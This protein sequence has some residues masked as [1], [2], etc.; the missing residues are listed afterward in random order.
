MNK[1][2]PKYRN[3]II[4]N[5]FV[6]SILLF[7]STIN[8]FA[9]ESDSEI[10]KRAMRDEMK[11]SMDS[12]NYKDFSKPFFIGY[13]YNQN[14]SL[15]ISAKLGAITGS[16]ISKS[17]DNSVRLMVGD[18][19]MN[20]ENYYSYSSFDNGFN[21]SYLPTPLE[22]EYYGIRR[23]F[24]ASSDAV[25]KS[26]GELYKT[27]LSVLE[28][29][30]ISKEDYITPDFA[31]APVVQLE[32]PQPEIDFNKEKWE[33]IARKIS[34]VFIDYPEITSSSVHITIYSGRNYFI[35]TEGTEVVQPVI[36]SSISA[37][38]NVDVESGPSV[39]NSYVIYVQNP[40]EFPEED[41]LVN[42]TK[43]FADHLMELKSAPV[44]EDIY[45][46]PVLFEG[47]S[48]ANLFSSALFGYSG[49]IADRAQMSESANMISIPDK[50]EVSSIE[51]KIGKKVISRDLSVIALP[52]LK[53]YN[54]EKL[55]GSFEIDGEGV[56]PPDTLVL[57]KDGILETLLNGRTPS[58]MIRESNGHNRLGTYGMGISWSVGPGVI[59]VT[60]SNT[61]T[62][63]EL[64]QQ[65]FDLADE[66]DL[67]YVFIVKR[68]G[69][70]RHIN[71]GG[72]YKVNVADGT[73]Q[74]VRGAGLGSRNLKL[75]KKVEGVS[76]ST[77]MINNTSSSYYMGGA[78]SS[79]IVPN[80]VLIKELE[81][82]GTTRTSTN[83][84]PVVEN[85]LKK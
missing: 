31:R 76:D 42:E 64:M 40:E 52:K 26:A 56:I 59:Q 6:W 2:N 44:Y 19:Q 65:L 36:Q 41:V 24:W 12:L 85:P 61:N 43:A 39:S 7:I 80:S 11:R 51:A 53:S 77:I 72:I 45:T 55:M 67:E 16:N 84:L 57:I 74:L 66:E 35:N 27:K 28:K 9:Q 3:H 54:G 63:E 73:E 37:Y 71:L 23:T 70:S 22:I 1:I 17:N 58:I 14:E 10:I 29:H 13:R 25:Y 4:I 34:A 46:G 81:I 78:I 49:L 15:N 83:K 30:D 5:S 18:Y 50:P 32:I 48:S 82:E 47:E 68:D 38:A 20:D 69:N 79:Y 33:N 60:A 21:A 75:L 8:I 62:R